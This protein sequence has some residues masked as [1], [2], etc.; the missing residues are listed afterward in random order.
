MHKHAC[1]INGNNQAKRWRSQ[2]SRIENAYVPERTV[3][4]LCCTK[5]YNS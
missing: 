1:N 2:V 3:E 4:E 5:H